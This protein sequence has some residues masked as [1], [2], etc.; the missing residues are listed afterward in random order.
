MKKKIIIISVCLIIIF[1]I[2]YKF[3]KTENNI[4]ITFL[5]DNEEYK[6]VIVKNIDNIQINK[7]TEAGLE[8]KVITNKED[9]SSVY[10]D[11]L[12]I[13][14]G[15]ETKQACEDNTTIYLISLKNGKKKTITIECDWIII[16]D[17]RYIIEK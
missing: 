14:Y 12:N 7:Y 2:V 11:L 3:T 9:I 6:D 4:K 8:S 13:K 16:G 5:K 1:F 10:N 17:K 15:K